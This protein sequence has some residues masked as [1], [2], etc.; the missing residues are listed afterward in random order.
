MSGA[1]DRVGRGRILSYAAPGAAIKGMTL[2]LISYLPPVYAAMSGL[3]L[4][5]VG[6]VFMF[7]R[8]WDIVTDPLAGTLMD[9]SQPPLG[10]R[11]FWI[12]VSAP[13]LM[14]T[15]WPLFNPPPEAGLAWL[16]GL[17]IVFYVAWTILTI[18]HASWPAELATD[19]AER[20]RLIG[21]REWAGVIGMVVVL[22]TPI[23]IVG[24]E[25]PL[26]QQLS[27][28]GGL[29]LVLIPVTIIPTLL[30]LPK[31]G[32]RPVTAANRAH[33][34]DSW[35]LIGQSA[36]LRWLLLADLLSGSGYAANS[37]TLYFVLASY[38]AVG[39]Q[40]SGIM[41]CF[42]LGMILGIPILMKVSIRFGPQRCFGLAMLG[43]AL[44]SLGFALIPVGNAF[45]AMA[46][47]GALGF[48]TGGYQ[49]NLNAEMVRLAAHDLE[50]RRKDRTSQHLALL[51]MTN[52]LGYALAVGVVYCLLEIFAGKDATVSALPQSAL[53]VLGLALPAV[54]FTASAWAFSIA[55]RQNCGP[56]SAS[57]P[58]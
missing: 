10:R 29:L 49:F 6:I 57:M 2:P 43:S 54:L 15:L 56:A 55:R 39:A 19:Q 36:P 8:L 23:I 5:A 26:P 45:A 42:M 13:V 28:M 11:K 52:K 33:L 48:C 7:A 31:Q 1:V 30:F 21:W 37:A 9:R 25:A 3:S 12:A 14:A 44:A 16:A 24:K 40:Y 20:T 35:R 32:N 27:V 17:L 51:A 22:A 4:S 18:S 53:L 41:L 34:S 38:L 47:N 46:V 50:T 58:V